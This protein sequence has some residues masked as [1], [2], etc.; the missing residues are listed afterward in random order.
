MANGQ[1]FDK[2]K[3]TA[4]HRRLPFGTLLRVCYRACVDVVITDRG[5]Y[6]TGRDLDLSEKAAEVIGMKGKGVAWVSVT[7]LGN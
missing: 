2:E 6:V 1:P 5:P 4:A 3:L 7:K